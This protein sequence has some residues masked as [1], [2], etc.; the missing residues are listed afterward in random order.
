MSRS[1]SPGALRAHL[2]HDH[3]HEQTAD[4]TDDA[5]GRVPGLEPLQ[6]REVLVQRLDLAA[7]RP[8]PLDDAHA[9]LGRHGPP[10]APHEQLHAELGL[11]LAHVLGH[12]RLHGVQLVGGG[13]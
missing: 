1:E 5:E 3:R 6:H 7:D 11:E 13:R 2:G 4:G 10:P 12:V 9:E 8:G